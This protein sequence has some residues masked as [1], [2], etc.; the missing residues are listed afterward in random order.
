[1][2]TKLT[3]YGHAAMDVETGGYHLLVDP[4]LAEIR[5]QPLQLN[6]RRRILSSSATGIVTTLAIRCKLQNALGRR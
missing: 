5:L 1:M 3:W 4:F 2:S 6:K